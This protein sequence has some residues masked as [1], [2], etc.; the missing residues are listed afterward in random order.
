MVPTCFMPNLVQI[1]LAVLEK[2]ILKVFL[3]Y[4][5]MAAILN[6]GFA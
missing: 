4:M 3:P 2:K 1:P 5:D 6:N